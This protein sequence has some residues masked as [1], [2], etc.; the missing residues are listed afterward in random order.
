MTNISAADYISDPTNFNSH[1]ETTLS[2]P[3]G[4]YE[5][6]VTIIDENN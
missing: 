3:V 4:L 5:K 1:G 2:R 6:L